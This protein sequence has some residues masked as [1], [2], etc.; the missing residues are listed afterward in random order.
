L[1][2]TISSTIILLFFAFLIK[3][4]YAKKGKWLIIVY[5]FTVIA[6]EKK[7]ENEINEYTDEEE[8]CS[9]VAHM[10]LDS[11]GLLI[12]NFLSGLEE[13]NKNDNLEK[14]KEWFDCK[15]CAENVIIFCNSCIDTSPVQSELSINF[16]QVG[17]TIINIADIS[18]DEPLRFVR[19]HD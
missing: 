18:M 4:S 16:I 7:I 10:S 1:K 15:S 14:L 2:N 19:Y 5:I 11:T 17:D 9:L 12:N 8:F 13:N 3:G 6:C